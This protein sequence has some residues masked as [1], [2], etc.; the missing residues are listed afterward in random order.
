MADDQ[1]QNS[2]VGSNTYTTMSLGTQDG[3]VLDETLVTYDQAPVNRK[4]ERIVPSGDDGEIAMFESVG[5]VPAGYT[6]NYPAA[7]HVF[8]AAVLQCLT[9]I[10]I[11]SKRQTALL[12][13]I[14]SAVGDDD[15]DTG[16]DGDDDTDTN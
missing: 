14:L 9:T 12:H 7:Q 6:P 16:E 13:A 2:N 3:D 4:R 15:I 11:E 5:P 8:D 1:S 10:A